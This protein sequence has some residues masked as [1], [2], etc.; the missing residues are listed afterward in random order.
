MIFCFHRRQLKAKH[1]DNYKQY[2]TCKS[3]AHASTPE[4][5]GF[6]QVRIA[7]IQKIVVSL[8]FALV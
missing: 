6:F 5:S 8:H 1:P 7:A 4:I 3:T 2:K